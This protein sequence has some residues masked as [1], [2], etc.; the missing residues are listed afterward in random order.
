M[1]NRVLG[2]GLVL[3][4]VAAVVLDLGCSSSDSAT[5]TPAAP[6]PMLASYDATCAVDS[7]CVVV[8]EAACAPCGKAALSSKDAPRYTAALAEAQQTDT[9]QRLIQRSGPCSVEG[10]VLARCSSTVCG[11]VPAPPRDAGTSSDA[12]PE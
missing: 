12:S 7:D 2:C 8:S 9:C 6:L 11:L 3:T 5:E 1:M 10:A 4:A